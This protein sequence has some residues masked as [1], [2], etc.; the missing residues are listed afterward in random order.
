METCQGTTAGFRAAAEGATALPGEVFCGGCCARP[1]EICT[2]DGTQL[3]EVSN[4]L[5]DPN[6]RTLVLTAAARGAGVYE[7][8][9]AKRLP[10]RLLGAPAKE[11][12]ETALAKIAGRGTP[13][14]AAPLTL[15]TGPL[16]NRP[17]P[18]K[19]ATGD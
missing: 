16:L 4:W 14:V 11:P 17:E 9:G 1:G 7:A 2:A 12:P 8:A 19:L 5:I 13:T 10:C 18:L 15:A 3:S 6:L